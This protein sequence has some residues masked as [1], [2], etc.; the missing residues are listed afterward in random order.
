LKKK[1]LKSDGKMNNG[2]TGNINF[3]KEQQICILNGLWL[4]IQD[5]S[6]QIIKIYPDFGPLKGMFPF[7]HTSIMT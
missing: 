1:R 2:T 7:G 6:F 5:I 4:L 3:L